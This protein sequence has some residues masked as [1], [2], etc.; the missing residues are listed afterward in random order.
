MK[1]ESEMITESEIVQR[2]GMPQSTVH[3]ILKRNLTTMI[4]KQLT[5]RITLYDVRTLPVNITLSK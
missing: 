3:K 2:S 1:K 4:T 5:K